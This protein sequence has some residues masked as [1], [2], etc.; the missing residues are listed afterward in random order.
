MRVVWLLLTSS[1]LSTSTIQ[2]LLLLNYLLHKFLMAILLTHSVSSL[3]KKQKSFVD[4]VH[5]S[6]KH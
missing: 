4:F 6:F 2:M 1:I 5:V 3:K